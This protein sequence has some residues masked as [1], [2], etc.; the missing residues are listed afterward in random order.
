VLIVDTGPLYAA[1]ATRDRNHKAC[2]ELLEAE[3]RP[4]IVPIL[5]VAET[6][7]MLENRLGAA[8][9]VA[10]ARA[11][12]RGEVVVEEVT[13][14]DWHRIEQISVQ[15]QDLPLGIVD[16]SIVAV[17][18]RLQ[19][20]RIATLDRRHFSVVRPRHVAAFDLVPVLG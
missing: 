1:A 3:P 16:A 4:L 7:H 11:L 17:A 13:P 6:G 2:V 12:A 20:A 9:E 19:M 15:Y 18:E 10:F 8:A 14:A 5:V